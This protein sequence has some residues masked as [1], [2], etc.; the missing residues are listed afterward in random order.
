MI[1]S[2]APVART[3]GTSIGTT[4]PKSR[5]KIPRSGIAATSP[6]NCCAGI[7]VRARRAFWTSAA[8]RAIWLATCGVCFRSLKSP[9]SS[10]APPASRYRRAKSPARSFVQ[11][12]LL[13]PGD[14]GQLAGWAQFAVC[15]EVLEHLDDPA[16]LLRNASEY[17][18]PGCLL[19]RDRAGRPAIRIR[20]A[21]RPSPA[22]HARQAA[23]SAGNP[24]GFRVEQ[25]TTAGFPFFNL[26]RMVVICG[27][28]V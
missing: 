6:A 12:N 24:C 7:R 13:E 22:L 4:R 23:R 2:H 21:H 1:D 14:P 10:S 26:Y 27:E 20:P 16:L 3:I 25:A 9:G 5:N 11:R 8:D 28:A 19:D 17:L 18:A 15:A